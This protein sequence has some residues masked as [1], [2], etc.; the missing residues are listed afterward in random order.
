MRRLW[1][2]TTPNLPHEEGRDRLE[3]LLRPFERMSGPGRS[4]RRS[5]PFHRS[6]VGDTLGAHRSRG[7]FRRSYNAPVN[8]EADPVVIC[9]ADDGI[10]V[11]LAQQEEIFRVFQRLHRPTLTAKVQCRADQSLDASRERHGGLLWD[12]NPERATASTS[13][14]VDERAHSRYI[15]A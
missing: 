12:P 1:R 13:H 7:A 8:S 2:R 6:S 3:L 4:G 11:P 10:G 9:V 14:L 15:D 5:R